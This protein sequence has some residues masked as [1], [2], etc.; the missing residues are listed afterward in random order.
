MVALILASCSATVELTGTAAQAP[1]S[2]KGLADAALHLRDGAGV[3][4]SDT[5]TNA[6]G[7]FS[8]EAPRGD[9]VF[10]DVDADG[11]VATTFTGVSGVDDTSRLADES[12]YGW[13]VADYESWISP[14][15]PCAAD[16]GTAVGEVRVFGIVDPLTGEAPLVAAAEISVLDPIG[17]PV[18]SPCYLDDAGVHDP[19]ADRT[20][21]T[22]SFAVFGIPDGQWELRV[23]YDLTELTQGIAS[24]PVYI[25]SGQVAPR[26]PLLITLP[27][28]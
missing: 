26:F 16:G 25:E 3:P 9:V 5:R 10:L 23:T 14:F 28:L 27:Y 6:K 21:V 20:G 19:G 8:I 2:D 13:P 11:H 24:F 15:S 17:E 4:F 22:G 18:A 1:G 12:I 7:A